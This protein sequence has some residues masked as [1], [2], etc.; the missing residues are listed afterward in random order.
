MT[1]QTPPHPTHH[2]NLMS[3]ISKLLM[4]EFGLNFKGRFL[5]L[6][7]NNTYINNNN[8]DYNSNSPI[9]DRF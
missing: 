8:I 6:T 4:T 1:V 3:A 9:F 7:N 2:R 5:G